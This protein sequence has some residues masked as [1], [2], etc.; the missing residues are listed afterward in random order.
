MTDTEEMNWSDY[1]EL[2][3]TIQRRKERANGKASR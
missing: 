1:D 3:E 2:L